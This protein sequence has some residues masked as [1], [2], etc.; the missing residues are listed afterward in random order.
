M[1]KNTDHNHA[2]A[3]ACLL[4]AQLSAGQIADKENENAFQPVILRARANEPFLHFHWNW[5]LHD[6]STCSMRERICIDLEHGDDIIGY[7][8]SKTYDDQGALMLH[9]YLTGST[10]A[11]RDTIQQL[12]DGIPLQASIDWSGRPFDVLE[13]P[14]GNT[15]LINNI[16]HTAPKEGLTVIQNWELSAVAICKIGYDPR[17]KVHPSELSGD[18]RQVKFNIKEN[19]IMAKP[20]NGG[21]AAQ[22]NQTTDSTGSQTPPPAPSA[23]PPAPTGENTQLQPP[24]AGVIT[25]ERLTQYRAAF[26]DAS[27]MEYL[28]AGLTFEQALEKDHAKLKAATAQAQ[29]ENASLK[30]KLNVLQA[31]GVEIAPEF[32]A[33]EGGEIKPTREELLSGGGAA[34]VL[35]FGQRM[36]RAR[37]LDKAGRQ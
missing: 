9:G 4:I 2:P 19:S 33:P 3:N 10:Q 17:T 18:R 12:R 30:N 35:S 13:I 31:T 28:S 37:L 26:G 14:E 32:D 29:T 20:Q 36:E 24:P 34:A 23:T 1:S 15:I 25:P 22:Q 6:F 8:D 16:T 5:L 7:I 21:D 11:S 27:A